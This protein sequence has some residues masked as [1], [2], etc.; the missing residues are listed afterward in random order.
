MGIYITIDGG[1]T[2][3]RVS[4]VTENEVIKTVKIHAGAGS[5]EKNYLKNK[6]K[7]T[8][9]ELSEIKMP[10]RILASGMITSEMGLYNLPHIPAPAGISELH[11]GM[12]R[13][14]L[15]EISDVPF[16][17]V[18]GVKIYD[19]TL[20]H[21]DMMRGEET[22]LIGLSENMHC[23][24][25]YILPGSHSKIIRTDSCGRITDFKTTLTGEMIWALSQDTILKIAVNLSNSETNEEYL[26]KGYQYCRD[27]GLNAALFKTRIL[28]NMF[29]ISECEIYSFFM[30]AV[31]QAEIGEII[32]AKEGY[33]TIAGK[34]QIKNA[35]VSLLGALCNK[36]IICVS[37]KTAELAPS[38][39]AVRIYEY[40]KERMK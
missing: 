27:I 11:N 32:K 17:F 33:V 24:S 10:K 40:K 4:L 28:K 25:L 23:N 22:E 19:G 3:T 7:E 39:G 6:I 15:P 16:L 20:E 30:G 12:C 9:S 21:T 26:I 38:I 14:E 8:I 1:T 18:P 36:K 35:M 34:Q 37:D 2:N 5:C 31:L 13:A 29:S